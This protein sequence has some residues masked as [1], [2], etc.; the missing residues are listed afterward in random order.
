M[1][2]QQA[3]RL[4]VIKRIAG[5]VIFISAVISTFISVLKF[6]EQ[7]SGPNQVINAFVSDFFHVIIDMM[8]FNTP[9]LNAFWHNS[10]Q[11]D[12]SHGLFASPNLVFW[13]IYILVF[14]GLA[15]QASGARMS[16]QVKHIREGVEDQ[17]VLEQARGDSGISRAQ[18]EQRIVMPQ[19]TILL[20]IFPLYI[21]PVIIVIVGYF[22]FKL[23][24]ML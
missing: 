6:I 16:R 17:M 18:L 24:G 23:L 14:I 10:L 1:K 13:G 19:H 3:G 11:S 20:Q 12:F 21:L 9:F 7:N 5:W 2:Y 8:R 15:L 4:A 22:A